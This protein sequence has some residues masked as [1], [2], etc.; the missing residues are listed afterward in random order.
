ML[1]QD[2]QRHGHGDKEGG[3]EVP[4][5]AEALPRLG[6]VVIGGLLAMVFLGPNLGPMFG[7]RRSA[8]ARATSPSRLLGLPLSEFRHRF[9]GQKVSDLIAQAR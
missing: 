3:H 4:A 7:I 9:R 1:E 2:V 8:T 6:I 5:H